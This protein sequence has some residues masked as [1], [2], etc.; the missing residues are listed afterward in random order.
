[1]QGGEEELMVNKTKRGC[2]RTTRGSWRVQ[3]V[4]KNGEVF[5]SWRRPSKE[6][7]LKN[8]L[9]ERRRREV[10]SRI[11]AGLRQQGNYLLPKHPDKNDVLKALCEEAG[12]LVD[13]DGNLCRKKLAGGPNCA[14]YSEEGNKE[15]GEGKGFK[16][17]ELSLELTLSITL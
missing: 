5:T 3:R 7:R 10:T 15:A 12:Y 13:E 16:K 9:R 8:K 17:E 1:M 14:T 4:K 11:F 2:I 6:E